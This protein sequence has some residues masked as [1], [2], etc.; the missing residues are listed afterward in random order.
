MDKKKVAERLEKFRLSC[1]ELG[2]EPIGIVFRKE[3]IQNQRGII[4]FMFGPVLTKNDLDQLE[5]GLAAKRKTL[6]L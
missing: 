6:G 5:E 3:G 1:E 4:G 2:A